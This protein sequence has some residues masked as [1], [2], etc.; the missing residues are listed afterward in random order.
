MDGALRAYQSVVGAGRAVACAVGAVV[1]RGCGAPATTPGERGGA[2]AEGAT[3]AD[4]TASPEG[5]GITIGSLD[6]G[7]GGLLPGAG[8]GAARR[9]RSTAA[10][11][12]RSS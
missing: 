3:V 11:T 12:S 4:A 10:A 6:G 5:A 1:A 7:L 8:S 2:L 9:P